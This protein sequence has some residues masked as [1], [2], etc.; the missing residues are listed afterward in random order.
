MIPSGPANLTFLAVLKLLLVWDAAP[1]YT[2]SGSSQ[3]GTLRPPKTPVDATDHPSQPCGQESVGTLVQ[4]LRAASHVEGAKCCRRRTRAEPGRSGDA[5]QRAFNRRHPKRGSSE[6]RGLCRA[7]VRTHRG[8]DGGLN[9]ADLRKFGRS[10]DA[11]QRC[12]DG[13]IESS[14]PTLSAC[15]ALPRRVSREGLQ[16]KVLRA[17]VCGRCISLR[18]P[19]VAPAPGGRRLVW[20]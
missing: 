9:W 19:S 18:P 7:E 15:G 6:A 20:S 11:H 14:L 17:Q 2:A 10:L 3:S 13:Q 1:A 16:C 12:V 5:P 4:T 8:E